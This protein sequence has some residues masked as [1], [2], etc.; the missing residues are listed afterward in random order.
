M[1]PIPER[2]GPFTIDRELG[3]SGLGAVFAGTD[4]RGDRPVAIKALVSELSIASGHLGCFERDARI[5]AG[6]KHPGIVPVHGIETLAGG[7]YVVMDMIDGERLADRLERDGALPLREALSLGV[8]IAAALETAHGAAIAHRDL[9]PAN[10]LIRPDGSPVIVH[11]GLTMTPPPRD[12]DDGSPSDKAAVRRSVE[13]DL[14][15]G[16]PGYMSPEQIR[17]EPVDRRTDVWSFGCLLYECLTGQ[18]AFPGATAEAR[19][20]AALRANPDLGALPPE[21]SPLLR[22]LLARCFDRAPD[23]RVQCMGDVRLEL[24]DDLAG[25]GLGAASVAHLSGGR[26]RAPAAW[27]AIAI[28]SMLAAVVFAVLWLTGR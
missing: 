11:F 25:R 2:L 22:R 27:R 15:L 6:L 14:L 24:E 23:R 10:V 12:E 1:A 16:T 17:A 3:T 28:V 26:T 9:T 7:A 5:L 20:V 4:T 18:P 13:A 8:E 21:C 19:H